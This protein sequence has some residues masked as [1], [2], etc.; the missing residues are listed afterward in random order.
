M[1][2]FTINEMGWACWIEL[3]VFVHRFELRTMIF[4][5]YYC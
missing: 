1:V 5:L 4:L 2:F 3:F